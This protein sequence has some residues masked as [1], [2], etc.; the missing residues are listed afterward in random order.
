MKEELMTPKEIHDEIIYEDKC[1]VNT[2]LQNL[3]Y[4]KDERKEVNIFKVI[5]DKD[6]LAGYKIRDPETG[7]DV[8]L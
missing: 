3:I 4:F 6:K 5:N 7:E 2:L 1:G 8:Q